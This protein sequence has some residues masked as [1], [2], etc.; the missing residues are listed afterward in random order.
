MDVGLMTS[1]DGLE[2]RG[3]VLPGSIRAIISG[4]GGRRVPLTPILITSAELFVRPAD[5]QNN[6]R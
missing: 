2:V 6:E 5:W 4:A 3:D 1:R